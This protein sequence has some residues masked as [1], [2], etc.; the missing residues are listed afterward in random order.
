[1]SVEQIVSG[2][3]NERL[4]VAV[5]DDDASMTALSMGFLASLN[6]AREH[7]TLTNEQAKD[8]YERGF[9]I[10]ERLFEGDEYHADTDSF[11][12]NEA[13]LT[14]TPKG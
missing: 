11:V 2:E 4:D 7:G 5:T 14:I 8:I 12:P 1:M 10:A 3:N 6:H 13:M 9:R